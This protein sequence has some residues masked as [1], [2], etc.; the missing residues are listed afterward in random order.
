VTR[1]VLLD[2]EAETDIEAAAAWYDA[3]RPGLGVEFT[4][5][6]RRILALLEAT[7]ETFPL[8][9]QDIRRVLLRRFPYEVFYVVGPQQVTV[10]ACMHGH[11]DPA[12]WQT[13]R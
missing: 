1:P 5:E 6:V 12:T 3:Q 10:I 7:P 8:V 13:R 2:P 9:L 11:R 4:S